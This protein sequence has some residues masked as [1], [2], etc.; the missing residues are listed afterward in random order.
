MIASR[1]VL[2][3]EIFELEYNLASNLG[4]EHWRC[5]TDAASLLF[6][7]YLALHKLIV[8]SIQHE[9]VIHPTHSSLSQFALGE[10][11]LFFKNKN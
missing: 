10:D 8:V 1:H 11:F 9:N 6:V 3:D 4:S 7:H 5:L 2:E